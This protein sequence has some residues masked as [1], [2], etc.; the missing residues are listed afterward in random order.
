MSIAFFI[1]AFGKWGLVNDRILQL[2]IALFND[3]L[4]WRTENSKFRAA[5]GVL[6]NDHGLSQ[7]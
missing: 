2:A 3:D 7:A 6:M 5:L 1:L 4:T